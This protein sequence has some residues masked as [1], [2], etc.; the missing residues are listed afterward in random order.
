[1]CACVLL[2]RRRGRHANNRHANGRHA[3]PF[4]TRL[5]PPTQTSPSRWIAQTKILM[6]IASIQNSSGFWM[7]SNTACSTCMTPWRIPRCWRTWRYSWARMTLRNKCCRKKRQV[8]HHKVWRVSS[9]IGGGSRVCIVCAV[10]WRLLILEASQSLCMCHEYH[11]Q[12]CAAPFAKSAR[13]TVFCAPGACRAFTSP[14]TVHH[15][16]RAVQHT[17]HHISS[18][19]T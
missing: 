15:A 1:M 10:P 16:V 7:P 4:T 19:Y 11:P 8:K 5:P 2:G 9:V 17:K 6:W 13:L 3:N 12:N 18:S 14:W